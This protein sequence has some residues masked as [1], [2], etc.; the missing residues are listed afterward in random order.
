MRGEKRSDR[1]E[2]ASNSISNSN[3]NKN[4][5]QMFINIGRS[6]SMNAK[7]LVN[8]IIRRTKLSFN[9][10]IDLQLHKRHSTFKV[11]KSNIS[12]VEQMMKGQNVKGRMVLIKIDKK[13][14]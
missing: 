10:I 13:S 4:L 3:D 6:D 12:T 5:T 11:N 1:R 14:D 7:S 9:D 8:F 2:S